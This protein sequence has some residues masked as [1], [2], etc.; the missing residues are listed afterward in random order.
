MRYILTG[1]SR[2]GKTT[3]AKKLA[4]HIGGKYIDVAEY[5]LKYIKRNNLVQQ[6][7]SGPEL[8]VP[9]GEM[10][11]DIATGHQ[12]NILEI[13]SDWPEE[14]LPKIIHSYSE[15]TTLIYC[16]CPLAVCL[17]RNRRESRQV[18]ENVIKAQ[19]AY[20]SDFYRRLAETLN[21]EL[22]SVNTNQAADAVFEYVIRQL[23]H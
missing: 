7:F 13:A 12:W 9:Y 23:K 16:D 14:F 22:I 17:E 6:E 4:E 3:L 8:K 1:T 5:V 21:M 20:T 2:S 10:V 15:P 19:A 11:R 18:P